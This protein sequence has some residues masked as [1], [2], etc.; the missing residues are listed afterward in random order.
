MPKHS[1]FEQRCDELFERHVFPEHPICAM[2]D[3]KFFI[4]QAATDTMDAATRSTPT[5]PKEVAH[6]CLMA[7]RAIRAEIPTRLAD[8]IRALPA[9][10][11][12]FTESRHLS[13]HSDFYEFVRNK[14]EEANAAALEES[15]DGIRKG[16]DH[17]SDAR[18]AKL[19]IRASLFA[20]LKRRIALSTIK[21]GDGTPCLDDEEAAD[22]LFNYW[23]PVFKEGTPNRRAA[24]FLLSFVP[25]APM[26]EWEL[27]SEPFCDL[28]DT[29]S[30]SAPGPDGISYSCWQN[31]G[32]W[33][34]KILYEEYLF[35]LHGHA[36]AIDFNIS[37]MMFLPKGEQPGDVSLVS[38]TAKDTRPITLA[39]TDCKFIAAA[40]NSP[41]AEVAERVTLKVQ[42]GFIKGRQMVGNIIST[43]DEMRRCMVEGLDNAAAIFLTSR[44]PSL[45]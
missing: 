5:S 37:A 21:K 26:V 1:F 19:L 10:A 18:K 9:L 4:K 3:A 12:F 23:A 43:E 42:R 27:S 41:M 34:K 17:G 35:I 45:A 29:F 32:I 30:P 24:R 8:A 13:R 6:W 33:A 15:A 38:R 40:I 39:N 2:D 36:P 11:D 14:C 20:P 7:E 16:D 28:L 31:A 44:R 22:E 25:E